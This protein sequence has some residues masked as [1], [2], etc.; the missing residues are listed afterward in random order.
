MDLENFYK[1]LSPAIESI[2][3][4]SPFTEDEIKDLIMLAWEAGYDFAQQEK[5]LNKR[6]SF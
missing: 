1:Q 6:A 2:A 5:V 3:K 4:T